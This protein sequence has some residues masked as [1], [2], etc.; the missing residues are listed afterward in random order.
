MPETC[1]AAVQGQGL[2]RPDQASLE[3]LC[4]VPSKRELCRGDKKNIQALLQAQT[5]F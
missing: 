2:C 5:F 1:T 3:S 4:P